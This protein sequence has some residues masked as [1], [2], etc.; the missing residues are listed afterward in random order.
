M[1]AICAARGESA[2]SARAAAWKEARRACRT[3]ARLAGNGPPVRKLGS[4]P[5]GSLRPR[6]ARF[7]SR[8]A[9]SLPSRSR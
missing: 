9:R 7:A 1:R 3:F 5:G 6:A 4:E 2:H 8:S